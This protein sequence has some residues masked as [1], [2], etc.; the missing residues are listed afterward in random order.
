MRSSVMGALC[1]ENMTKLPKSESVGIL[2]EVR[3]FISR[4]GA[5]RYQ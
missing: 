1:L 3:V 4:R 2:W 5:G